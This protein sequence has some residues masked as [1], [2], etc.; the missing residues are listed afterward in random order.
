MTIQFT[1]GHKTERNKNESGE[2]DK[3]RNKQG[4]QQQQG[5]MYEVAAA[6]LL[7]LPPGLLFQKCCIQTKQ[8]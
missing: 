5:A 7:V 2:Q 4:Q 1:S 8:G 6:I 3:E